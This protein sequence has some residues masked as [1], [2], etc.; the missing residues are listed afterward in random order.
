MAD[1]RRERSWLRYTKD[2][3]K[4]KGAKAFLRFILKKLQ[5][6]KQDFFQEVFLF[7]LSEKDKCIDG[8]YS[9]LVYDKALKTYKNIV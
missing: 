3:Q 9:R 8:V 7:Y 1:V 4:T 6:E 2:L 5:S